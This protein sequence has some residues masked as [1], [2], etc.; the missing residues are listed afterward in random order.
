[1][2]LPDSGEVIIDGVD[3]VNFP[4]KARQIVSFCQQKS[5]FFPDL[6]VWEHLAFYATVVI[7][8]EP[9]SSLD[10]DSRRELWMYYWRCAD[11][12]PLSSFRRTTC[13]RLTC[14]PTESSC[15]AVVW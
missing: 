11:E 6:T 8:D 15:Y 10:P 3:V 14:S 2:L 4:E 7:L 12:A 13:T 9:S 5:L 1:M